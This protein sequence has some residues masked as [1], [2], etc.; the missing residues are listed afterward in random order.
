MVLSAN[1]IGQISM[2]KA[3]DGISGSHSILFD[4][5]M[6]ELR[7]DEIVLNIPIWSLVNTIGLKQ[8]S[9]Y[10]IGNFYKGDFF[11]ET[12]VNLAMGAVITDY[13]RGGSG[14]DE[15]TF[16]SAIRNVKSTYYN[17]AFHVSNYVI[18]YD[19]I[20]VLNIQCDEELISAIERIYDDQTPRAVNEAYDITHRLLSTKYAGTPV[21]QSYLA[22]LV[23]Q[24]QLLTTVGPI[25]FRS[26]I[27]KKIL[28]KP[29]ATSYALGHYDAYTYIVDSY[30]TIIAQRAKKGAIADSEY[31]GKLMKLLLMF[32]VEFVNGDCGSEEYASIDVTDKNHVSLVGSY[33][34]DDSLS[35]LRVMDVK[36]SSSYIGHTIRVRHPSGCKLN[37]PKK[38]CSVCLGELTHNIPPVYNLGLFVSQYFIEIMSQLIIGQ[39][40]HM[41]SSK[42]EEYIFKGVA[43]NIFTIGDDGNVYMDKSWFNLN[44]NNYNINIPVSN[45]TFSEKYISKDINSYSRIKQF[46]LEIIDKITGSRRRQTV[47]IASTN[48]KKLSFTLFML[49]L[50]GK[51]GN[52]VANKSVYKIY[53]NNILA[54]KEDVPVFKLPNIG[55]SLETTP[56]EFETILVGAAATGMDKYTLL[57][58]LHAFMLSKMFIPYSFTSLIVKSI[59]VKS[60]KNPT[61]T[62]D[63]DGII[64]NYE[65]RLGTSNI[66]IAFLLG[67]LL[68][69]MFP[70]EQTYSSNK[71]P[72]PGD[73][74]LNC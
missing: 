2:D 66:Y 27:N 15:Y 51:I 44:K 1:I 54:L 5:K 65:R 16:L 52:V 28:R 56:R 8:S 20:D 14:I 68:H 33:F 10:L 35:R 31:F 57:D 23:R 50:I 38:I 3:K 12:A 19:I 67:G 63:D 39:K 70:N 58:E 22:G 69:W 9:R 48:V 30:S 71:D 18:C 32:F 6:V 34:T 40:H 46:E 24:Q 29:I 53:L 47:I 13:R 4:D 64:I 11:D 61:L 36:E 43:K 41:G 7:K 59:Y 73:I 74:M 37:D 42:E 26:D 21:G 55:I 45:I 60:L 72:H 62:N 49:R 25:G 17:Q